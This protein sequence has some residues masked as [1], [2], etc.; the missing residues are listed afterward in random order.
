[1][2]RLDTVA[3]FVA[4][5]EHG[6]FATAARRLSVPPGAVSRAIAQLEAVGVLL[7]DAQRGLVDFPAIR[8]GEEVYLCW[9]VNEPEI[10]YWHPLDTGILGRQPL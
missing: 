9:L 5:A 2:D 1:M 4:I 3:I 8:D 7:R 10:G 6:N